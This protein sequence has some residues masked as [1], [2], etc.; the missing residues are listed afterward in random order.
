MTRF[1]QVKQILDDSVNGDNIHAHGPFWRNTTRD[2]F[3]AKVIFGYPLLT[4][5]NGN[6]SNLV[7]ALRGEAPF[8]ANLPDPPP[9]AIFSR[10]PAN[11]PPVSDAN[12]DFIRQWIDDGCPDDDDDDVSDIFLTTSDKA[13]E[14]ILHNALWREFDN[15]AMFQA[16]P[17]VSDAINVFF[18]V[19]L[20]WR[21][22][23]NDPTQ[24]QAWQTA[25]EQSEVRQAIK[26]LSDRQ[27]QSFRDHFG[28]PIPLP[29]FLDAFERFGDNSLPDD[30]QRPEDRRHNMN[31]AG[32][33][34]IWSAFCDACLRLELRTEFWTGMARGLL[35][36]LLNDGLFRGRF[37]VNGFAAD[38]AG[39]Q[40][41]RKLVVDLA[42]SDLQSELRI[43]FT[44]SGLG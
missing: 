27:Y 35:I 36:G 10:M 13:V 9:G 15:W 43:R 19:T 23:A 44:D 38:L 14:P 3:V 26:L 16:S 34:F 11:R 33:W 39:K 40:A 4:A 24:E 6:E 7:K 2:E 42:D 5:G 1:D 17:E 25:I 22:F 29:D 8:G 18:P 32:M 28:L 41:I 20:Q 12:I 21:S 37:N 31:G 30:P